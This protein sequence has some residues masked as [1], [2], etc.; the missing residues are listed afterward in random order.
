MLFRLKYEMQCDKNNY[1]ETF[2]LVEKKNYERTLTCTNYDQEPIY[3]MG[4][5]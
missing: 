2:H 1:T 4:S 5:C 3:P